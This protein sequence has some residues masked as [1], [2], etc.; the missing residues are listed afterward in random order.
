VLNSLFG[1]S[2]ADPIAGLIIAAIA[3]REGIEAWKGD[4]CCP[5]TILAAPGARENAP[6]CDCCDD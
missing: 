2:W 1:W 6:G 4:T 3:V 5:S